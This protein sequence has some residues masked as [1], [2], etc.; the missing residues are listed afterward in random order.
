V[1]IQVKK[2]GK[3]KVEL[4]IETGKDAVKQKYDEVYAHIAKEAKIPGFRPGKAPRNIIEKKYN[5]AAKSSVIQELVEDLYKQ[6]IDKEKISVINHPV[7]SDINLKNDGFSFKAVVEVRPE[8]NIK[9]YK[10]I[11]IKRAQIELSDEKVNEA[12][13]NIKKE[14]KADILDDNFAKS[15]GYPSLSNLKELVR[16]QL[17]VSYSENARRQH[18]S[19][20]IEFLIS[21]AELDLPQSV[22]ENEYKERLN[23]LDYQLRRQGLTKEDIDKRKKDAEKALREAVMKDLKIYF[24]LDKIAQLENIT[25][26]E[27]S[28]TAKTLEFLFKEANWTDK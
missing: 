25:I 2:I 21:N 1:N 28:G 12:L 13:E 14:K 15:I 20:V 23:M 26:D 9:K 5:E 27:K 7:I 18:E 6:A 22:L 19:Q 4:N 3:S 10:G 11:K 16:N 8:V 17:F 24:I